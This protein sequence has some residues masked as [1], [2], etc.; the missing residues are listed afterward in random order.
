MKVGGVVIGQKHMMDEMRVQIN[1]RLHTASSAARGTAMPTGLGKLRH[2]EVHTLWL[3]QKVGVARA[4][5]SW[6]S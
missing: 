3:Q 2:I 6:A 1:V 4:R 5:P